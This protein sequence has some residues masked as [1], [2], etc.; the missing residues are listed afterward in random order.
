MPYMIERLGTKI[1]QD[2]TVEPDIFWQLYPITN[3]CANLLLGPFTGTLV[4]FFDLIY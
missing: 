3:G 4:L 2:H 1:S